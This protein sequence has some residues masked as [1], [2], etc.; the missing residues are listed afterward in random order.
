MVFLNHGS[1]GAAPREV[2]AAQSRLRA[3]MEAEPVRF[4]I[5]EFDGLMDAAR[6]ALAALLKTSVEGLVPVPNATIGVA[7]IIANLVY[8]G[9]IGAGDEVIIGDHEY[10]ACINNVRRETQRAGAA[11]TTA[12][13]PFPIQSP[14]QAVDA[15]LVQVSPRTKAALISHVTSPTG[16][17]LPIERI[18][19]ALEAKGVAC[20]VDGAHAPGMVAEL[21]LG[22]LNAS[23]Y[24]SNLHKWLCAP[25]GCAMLA[26]REDRRNGFRP[27]VLSNNADK[28]R[29]GRKHLWTE[30]DYIG[31]ND[32][33]A[34]MA[35]PSAIDFLQRLTPGGINALA[36]ANRD[37][38][39]QARAL[40]TRELSIQPPAPDS[41]IGSICTLILP[42]HEEGRDARLV[43]RPTRYHDA[44]QDNLLRNWGIQVPVWGLA[45]RPGR[46]VRFSAQA[47]NAMGEYAY[48]AHALASELDKER[49]F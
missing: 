38:C 27:L 34:W 11:I 18:V 36:R 35:L 25:K 37:L 24:T 43:Q 3:M 6:S 12:A 29:P 42:P 22:R 23:F 48:L 31:T 1:F 47:Y 16:L 13:I 45:G 26:V 40:L 4:F 44:L 41:M 49:A 21:D 20:I 10:P 19:A 7:T 2:L 8:Q 32:Y 33:T 9:V 46:F 5:E 17:V 15:Y 28:P 30:F 39:L 14:D